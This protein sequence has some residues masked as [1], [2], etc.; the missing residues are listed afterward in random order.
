MLNPGGVDLAR[1]DRRE[2]VGALLAIQRR[3]FGCD[4]I[5]DI[6]AQERDIA[7]QRAV[8][9]VSSKACLHLL[10]GQLL[11]LSSLAT[12]S[13]NSVRFDLIGDGHAHA[14]G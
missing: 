1:I 6:F 3:D 2:P 5:G 7:V 10:V 13:L 12:H 14:N 11:Q 4:E 9:I 8:R